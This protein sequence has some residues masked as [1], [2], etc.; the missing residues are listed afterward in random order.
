MNYDISMDDACR[1]CAA[2][3]FD[4]PVFIEN[5][6]SLL[7]QK[8]AGGF[9]KANLDSYQQEI[10][11]K[12]G[13]PELILKSSDA[14][15]MI[16]K[17]E[18]GKS[19]LCL[20]PN[21]FLGKIISTYQLGAD[22]FKCLN[23]LVKI[24]SDFYL[25][26]D[27][28]GKKQYRRSI[29][30]ILLEYREFFGQFAGLS[31]EVSSIMSVGKK[32]DSVFVNELYKA[33]SWLNGN[34]SVILEE[35][36]KPFPLNLDILERVDFDKVIIYMTL[37][38]FASF[39]SGELDDREDFFPIVKNYLNY[40]NL[41]EK[42]EGS[43]RT[44]F[45]GSV[46]GELQNISSYEL[47]KNIL[48]V[49]ENDSLDLSE[50]GVKDEEDLLNNVLTDYKQT[51]DEEEKKRRIEEFKKEILLEWE[52]IPESISKGYGSVRG[53][54]IPRTAQEKYDAELRKQRVLDDKIEVLENSN[55]LAK[56]KGVDKF[57]GYVAF[58]YPNGLVLLDKF[59][60]K[61]RYGLEPVDGEALYVMT[62]DKFKEF[63]QYSKSELRD[64]KRIDPDLNTINH[65]K[66][67]V[68][69][70]RAI[71]DNMDYDALTLDYIESMIDSLKEGKKLN[72]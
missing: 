69:R 58:V 29:K 53:I 70:V 11:K 40:Y 21:V 59:Y 38:A 67:F 49:I 14:S 47:N 44:R 36:S 32:V 20:D 7:K 9:F 19:Y 33:F 48:N 62:I 42:N 3:P 35:F 15:L 30:R 17:G 51:L 54:S 25:S 1:Y 45:K 18:D 27:D 23:D 71:L 22:R 52:I 46:T 50:Y 61:T 4:L 24:N 55:Y 2:F 66:N 60:K 13:A 34:L 6:G 57:Q 26:V 31:N 12:L 63:S 28:A 8:S 65:T 43:Y 5:Y 41:R 10:L 72:D 37:V 16:K 64:I 56:L 68:K 39:R